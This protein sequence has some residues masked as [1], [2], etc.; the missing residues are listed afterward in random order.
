M[1][2]TMQTDK[3]EA[4][5]RREIVR[6]FETWNRDNWPKGV[7]G[8]YD[9]PAPEQI[10]AATATL[11]FQLRGQDVVMR[12]SS[13]ESYRL[14]LRCL[15]YAVE[16][17]RMNEKR[18]IGDTMRDA[19][20][21]LPAPA[22]TRDPFE[23]LGVRPDVDLALAEAA[24]RVRA[25]QLHPDKGGSAEQMAELNAAMDLVRAERQVAV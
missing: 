1:S 20:L 22:K 8:N 21:Q 12:C 15:F 5:S 3:T 9:F 16:A 18:G 23:V 24:Y 4:Q 17:M 19:Y 2:Y 25:N 14:N 6:Q 7:I 10:G 11:R 13:Q